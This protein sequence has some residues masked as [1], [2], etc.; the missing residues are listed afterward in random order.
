MFSF[1]FDT[2]FTILDYKLSYLEF[3]ATLFGL[4]SVILAT[5]KN[6]LTWPIGLVNIVLSFFLFHKFQ[7]YADMLLQV[8]YLVLSISGWIYWSKAE[9]EK[10]IETPFNFKKIL[11]G[12]GLVI[13]LTFS[14][15]YLQ[16][17][18]PTLLPDFFKKAPSYPFW[19]ALIVSLSIYGTFLL[20][21]QIRE[22]WLVWLVVNS[23]ASTLYAIKEMYFTSILYVLFFILAYVGW[24]NWKK[25]NLISANLNPPKN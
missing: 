11:I 10:K 19:D 17:Q 20:A 5:Q 14:I 4:A 8:F 23:L 1:L 12:L 25:I 13:V 2:F 9:T 6:G 3:F 7:L 22:N 24:R 21:R 18:L 16:I 15:A